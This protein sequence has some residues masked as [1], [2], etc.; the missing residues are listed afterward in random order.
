MVI[1]LRPRCL[2]G[3]TRLGLLNRVGRALGCVMLLVVCGAFLG[4][5]S[6]DTLTI[7]TW[8]GAYGQSQEIAYFK[9]FTQQTGTKIKVVPYD[10][11]LAGIKAKIAGKRPPFDV[12]DLSASALNALCRDGL[13]DRIDKAS[14]GP[15]PDGQS[16][17]ED[18]LDGALP[19]CGVASVAWSTAIAFD[20]KALAKA[21]PTKI[22]DLLDTRRFPGKRALPNSPRYTLEL[23]LL[24][25]GV[26]PESVY[27]ELGT[28]S[29]LD[30]AFQAL[31]KIKP[32]ILWWDKA[33]EPIDWLIEKKVAMA[34]SYSNRLF[35]AAAGNKRIAVL[36]N[37][38]IYDLDLWAIPK[39]APNKKLAKQFIA[40]A[41]EPARL[42]AQA[43]L[44][45]YGPMRKSA[46]AL[47]GRH[48]EIDVEMKP[49]L[50]TTPENFQLALKFDE[51][52][53]TEHGGEIGKR[54]K[55]WREQ[56]ATADGRQE[57]PSKTERQ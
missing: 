14:L 57:K 50:P 18:F 8:G 44:I 26:A 10:G 47:V 45:A 52:W 40:F 4:G 3:R 31:D 35:H 56:T 42:A 1:C 27:V 25:D 51:A 17:A 30:R 24:A 5:K 16:A 43:E 53:W 22:A 32:H 9:P 37:G 12:V 33:Q 28:P 13:L 2:A 39:R 20:R 7:A 15:G 29:G 41:T 36:W 19:A 38:Q 46:V 54:F 34:A 21:A 55:T 23:A 49:Y 11:N 6:D 48:P